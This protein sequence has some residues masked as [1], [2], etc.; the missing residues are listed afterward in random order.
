MRILKCW[1]GCVESLAIAALLLCAPAWA[2]EKSIA[3]PI[4]IPLYFESGLPTVHATL[5]GKPVSL[6]IDLGGFSPLALNKEKLSVVP[7]E[8][9]K[10]LDHWQDANG[11][12]FAT[13][14]Y[15]AR[16]LVAGGLMLAGLHGSELTVPLASGQDGY[17]GFGLLSNYLVVFDYPGSELRLY[18]SGSG[19][20]LREECGSDV[21]P[22][23]IDNGVVES[24]VETDR[25]KFVFQLDTGSSQNILRPS[26][27]GMAPGGMMPDGMQMTSVVFSKYGLGRQDFGRM[28]FT[29]REFAAPN[30][31]GVLGT[32]FFK[33]RIVC[34]DIG[35]HVAAIKNG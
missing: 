11:H 8:F 18:P 32:P 7:V 26:A 33:S 4:R 25:G 6:I 16:N 15:L 19:T 13:R 23:D 34:V 9:S 10:R 22:I 12:V 24:T 3:G 35:K 30:V 28:R 31:D 2:S 27:L 29:L 1:L 14:T 21:I 20:A 5:S 17:L